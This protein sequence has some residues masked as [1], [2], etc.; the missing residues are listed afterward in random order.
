RSPSGRRLVRRRP[1]A[2]VNGGFWEFPNLEI[3][4]GDT[5]DPAAAARLLLG[6]RRAVPVRLGEVRHAITRHRIT[7]V[8]W[9]VRL[10]RP[11]RPGGDARWQTL[12]EL[13]ELP[14]VTAHRR[15][16]QRLETA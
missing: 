15:L 9:R 6:V 3:L 16:L 5:A 11:V 4:P 10:P 2:A 13:H 7:Q 1:A 14:M 12:A 8:A